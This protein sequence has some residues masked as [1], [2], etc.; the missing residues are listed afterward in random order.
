[1]DMTSMHKLMMKYAVYWEI[2]PDNCKM[3][4]KKYWVKYKPVLGKSWT[5]HMLGCLQPTVGLHV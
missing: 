3:H 1:M 5:E 2:L 4:S